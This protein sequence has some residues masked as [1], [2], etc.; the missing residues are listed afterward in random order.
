MEMPV[1][2]VCNN[3]RVTGRGLGVGG[4]STECPNKVTRFDIP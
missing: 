1:T 2:S 4:G 3:P